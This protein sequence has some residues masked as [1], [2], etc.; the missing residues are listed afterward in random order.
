[1]DIKSLLKGNESEILSL[2]SEKLNLN[3]SEVDKSIDSLQEGVGEA[4][5]QESSNN[6]VGTLL[7]LFSN[8]KNSVKSNSLISTI[9]KKVISSLLSKGFDKSKANSISSIAVPFVVNLI[10]SKVG[11][12]ENI[13]GGLLGGDKGNIAKGLLNKFFK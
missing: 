7:N 3:S 12:Q 9:T 2:F 1:M 13:L 5:V 11:G 6:G 10:S 4:L 8:N